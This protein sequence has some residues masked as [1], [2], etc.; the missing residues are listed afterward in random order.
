[1]RGFC[2]L[3]HVCF[4]IFPHGRTARCMMRAGDLKAAQHRLQVR[5]QLRA[6]V[7][8]R[9]RLLT[10]G[11]RTARIMRPGQQQLQMTAA[12]QRVAAGQREDFLKM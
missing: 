8:L 10:A 3:T 7:Q 5:V 12:A 9:Q 1:M 4:V 6:A 2:G 11:D